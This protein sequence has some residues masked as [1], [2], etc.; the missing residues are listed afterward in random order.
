M[1]TGIFNCTHLY[2]S[3]LL[4]SKSKIHFYI[5]LYTPLQFLLQK[6]SCRWIANTIIQGIRCTLCVYTNF[7]SGMFICWLYIHSMS[8]TTSSLALNLF[9]C[10]W[11][12]YKFSIFLFSIQGSYNKYNDFSSS[13]KCKTLYTYILLFIF[14]DWGLKYIHF[15]AGAWTFE[16]TTIKNVK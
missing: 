3:C 2:S 16:H 8:Q 9:N 12:E 11:T 4:F 15:S 6:C 5:R 14:E 7:M 13:K 10:K 1:N